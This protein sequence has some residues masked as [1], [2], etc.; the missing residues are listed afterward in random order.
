MFLLYLCSLALSACLLVV[1]IERALWSLKL[2]TLIF[3][4]LW[5]LIKVIVVHWM[6]LAVELSLFIRTAHDLVLHVKPA[7]VLFG[8]GGLTRF[9]L[10]TRYRLKLFTFISL[11]CLQ[12]CQNIS[13]NR[14]THL[15]LLDCLFFVVTSIRL[16][17]LLIPLQ[18]SMI[19]AI[20]ITVLIMVLA[21]NPTLLLFKWNVTARRLPQWILLIYS[22]QLAPLHH[23]PLFIFLPLILAS[24][25][26]SILADTGLC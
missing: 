23:N 17:F 20:R 22:P 9:Y 3:K 21:L 7:V 10:S 8:R 19:N 26:R 14:T 6:F 18:Q 16:N 13:L 11:V 1:L 5:L 24:K 2:K 4:R 25:H 15:I 12:S